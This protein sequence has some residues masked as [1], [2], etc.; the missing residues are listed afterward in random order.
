MEITFYKLLENRTEHFLS[1][2]VHLVH[3]LHSLAYHSSKNAVDKEEV[4]LT[5]MRPDLEPVAI[6][7]VVPSRYRSA[8]LT[9][10]TGIFH[11]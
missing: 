11:N 5:V 6:V 1:R 4:T 9:G 2:H 8:T 7:R 3:L 10:L